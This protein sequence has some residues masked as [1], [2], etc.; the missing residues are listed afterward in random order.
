M[1]TE[2]GMTGGL[3]SSACLPKYVNDCLVTVLLRQRK[4]CVPISVRQTEVRARF[5]QGTDD[6]DMTRTTVTQ[7]DR[8]YERGPT[9]VVDVIERSLTVDERTHH[10]N[11]PEMGCGD[12]GRSLV[13]TRSEAGIG[14][15]RDR[16]FHHFEIIQDSS[17]RQQ[18]V[19]VIIERV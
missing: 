16:Q 2:F 15:R 18:I 8:L 17:D 14:T 4:G 6:C 12:K 7:D 9:Q 10:F 1:T 3:R 5:D 19:P 11:V 13:G